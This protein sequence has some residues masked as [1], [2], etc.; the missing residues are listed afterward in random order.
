M[1]LADGGGGRSAPPEFGQ[2][3]LKVEPHAIP[4]ARA[5]FQRALDEFDAKIKPA[6]HDLPTRPWAA[7]PI[8]GE[9]A[10]AFNEQTSDKALTAL[11]TYRA[12]L[13]GV[14]EQLTMIEEQYRLIEGDNAAMWGK[15]LRDQD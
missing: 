14:I 7:D 15:H 6:V 5:A 4:Q 12:Q 2:R 8:S 3:K 9:T 11:K 13:V 1:H 10:K